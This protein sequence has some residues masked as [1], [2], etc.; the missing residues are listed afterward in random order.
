MKFARSLA[1][2]ALLALVCVQPVLADQNHAGLVVVF[3][4]NDVHEVCIGFAGSSISGISLLSRAGLGVVS[5]SEPDGGTLVCRI[6]EV[7][8][9]FPDEDCLCQCGDPCVAWHYWIWQGDGWELFDGSPTERWVELGD[10]DAWVWG[11]ADD[12]PPDLSADGPC[13]ALVA[14]PHSDVDDDAYPEPPNA[15]PPPDEP[16]PGVG[17]DV[18]EEST[19]VSPATSTP[20]PTATLTGV[21][22]SSA[23][24]AS[25]MT[26]TPTYT[27]GPSETSPPPTVTPTLERVKL[28]TETAPTPTSPPAGK[29]PDAGATLVVRAAT[30]GAASPT[31][32]PRPDPDASVPAGRLAAAAGLILAVVLVAAW[33]RWR[34]S[35]AEEPPEP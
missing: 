2:F 19:T 12:Q 31:D 20:R 17:D 1:Y 21:A 14:M 34:Q 35:Q 30:R 25:Q 15:S 22:S 6:A 9:S 23:T 7:G 16:Y 11:T 3:G 13:G 24:N 26:S 18:H 5:V 4:P 28:P 29:T 33:W 8:C 32:A 10:V 27:A